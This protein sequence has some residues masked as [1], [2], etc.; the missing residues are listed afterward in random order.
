MEL[1]RL[2]I[3]IS[4]YGAPGDWVSP[5]FKADDINDFNL[6]F[7]DIESSISPSTWVTASLIDT[8]TGDTVPGYSNVSF[9]ISLAGVDTTVTPQMKLRIH[10]GTNDEEETPRIS[11]IHIGG[12]RVLNAPALEGNG[13]EFS[14]SVSLID[15]LLNA[16][17]VAGTISMD[18]LHSSRPIKSVGLSGNF[19]SGLSISFTGPNGGV[20]GTAS[21]GGVSFTYPQPGFGVSV[22]IPTNGWIEKLVLTANFAEPALNPDIDVIED[23]THE[24]S[25]PFGNDYGHYGWQSLLSNIGSEPQY[26]VTA[27][28]IYLDG[29]NPT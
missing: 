27:A 28:S 24:W 29:S 3:R 11:K 16:T 2:V 13:W 19:S 12:K 7:I 21:Q 18:Y 8:S 15:G 25:F 23:D 4:N 6:G 14:P 1:R 26:Q 5:V 20:L 9:P 10:M 22:S 17:G